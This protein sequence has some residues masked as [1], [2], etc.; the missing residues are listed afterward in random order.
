MIEEIG[1]GEGNRTLV[2]SLEGFC[3]TIELHP[4]F[5]LLS[6]YSPS[7]LAAKYLLTIDR[8]CAAKNLRTTHIMRSGEERQLP[9]AARTSRAVFKVRFGN[10]EVRWQ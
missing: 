1:A 5:Q 6:T 10:A 3:S 4:Q 2:I 9:A 7:F 8:N